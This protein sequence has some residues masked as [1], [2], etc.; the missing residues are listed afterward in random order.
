MDTRLVSTRSIRISYSSNRCYCQLT[1]CQLTTVQQKA[2]LSKV[3][4]GMQ[5]GSHVTPSSARKPATINP[6]INPAVLNTDIS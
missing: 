2:E 3:M 4:K 5:K 6:A 1:S